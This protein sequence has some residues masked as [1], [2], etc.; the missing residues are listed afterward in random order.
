[1]TEFWSWWIIVIVAIMIVGSFVILHLTRKMEDN[2]EDTTGHVYDGIEEY[3]NPLPKWWLNMFYITLVFSIGYLVLYPGLGNYEGYFNWTQENAWE[4]EVAAAEEQYGPI[5]AQ[6]LNT[7][8]PSLGSNQEAMDM[9]K[10]IFLNYCAA[11]HGSFATGTPGYPNLMDDD[12]LYGGS[13]ET[14]KTTLI[15]GR[16]GMMPGFGEQLNEEQITFVTS[17]V[18]SLSGRDAPEK[19]VAEGKELYQM[20]CVACHGADGKGNQQLGAPNLTDST[21][22][23]GGSRKVIARTIRNGRQGN[24]PAHQEILGDAKL[25][26]VAAWVYNTSKEQS[27]Q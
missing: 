1:M 4:K 6:Y 18:T 9:G 21:W 13:P 17:Y 7:P 11:C 19:E 20:N 26:L 25:H 22:L 23:Y 8:I 12:W 2:G 3:N 14:I 10:R 24:M 15:N 5:F 16:Q 27:K